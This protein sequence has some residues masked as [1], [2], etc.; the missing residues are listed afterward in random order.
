MSSTKIEW[1]DKTW[2]PITGCSKISEGCANCYAERMAK[3]L[4]GR[5]GYPKENPFKV[6]IHKN[7]FL[8][9]MDWKK[10]QKIFV[11]SM[12]D[13]FHPEVPF[14]II[15]KIWTI[16][17][18]G[19]KH[20]FLILTKR[21]IR[22]LEFFKGRHHSWNASEGPDFA[23]PHIWL[24]VSIENQ[25]RSD[26]RIPILV[27]IPAARYF[28]S[29]EPILGPIN[30]HKYLGGSM[31]GRPDDLIAEQWGKQGLGWVIAG[32]ES[33]P[34]A[35][36]C[37]PDWIRSLRDQCQVAGVPFF[38]KGWGAWAPM[39][40]E[41]FA[42]LGEY[43]LGVRPGDICISEN[44]EFFEAGR[45]YVCFPNE[46]DGCQMRKIGKKKAGRLLE[47]REW[48]EFPE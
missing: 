42:F 17:N 16:M 26:E 46:S 15:N 40:N 18:F 37:H 4:A 5:C 20:T 30:L 44:G 12:A 35:R 45:R 43:R 6:T 19:R 3:R 10:P 48:N 22:M 9:P 36:P 23:P 28:V 25:A 24:G 39:N 1:C 7:K 2:S 33:G 34:G 29:C 31:T 32:G 47:G 38:F 11:C 21:P 13:L 41:D 14:E 27:Q 8:E